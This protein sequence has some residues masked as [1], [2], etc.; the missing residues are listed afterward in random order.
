MTAIVEVE[1]GRE[2]NVLH[3]PRQAVQSRDGKFVCVVRTASGRETRP[4][5]G[6]IYS[7]SAFIVESGLKEGDRVL[8]P[9]KRSR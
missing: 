1:T 3:L 4:V 6:R 9:R 5:T 2:T 8:V 7:S